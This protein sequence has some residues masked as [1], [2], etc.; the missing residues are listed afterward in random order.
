MGDADDIMKMM[1]R[2]TRKWTRQK[3]AE[4]RRPAARDYRLQRM[5][6][7]RD[8]RIKEAAWKVMQ[9]AYL[10]ASGS[11]KYPANARQVMY[12]ARPLSL[13]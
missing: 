11:D 9:Q 12:A 8:M 6:M 2:G 1:E 5:T 7:Q 13:N 4:E 3:K 10:K